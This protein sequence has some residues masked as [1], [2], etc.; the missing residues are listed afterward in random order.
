MPLQQRLL[1]L[2]GALV[3][4]LMVVNK[5]KKDKIL[6]VDSIFW[7]VSSVVMMV[8]AA[9]PE[10]AIA[11]S[12]I[13]G[14]QSPSNFVFFCVVGFL[15]VKVFGDSAEISLLKNRVD[16]LTQELALMDVGDTSHTDETN[17][18]DQDASR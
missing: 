15:F 13:L 7:V 2:C 16:E 9:V 18:S 3:A 10:L 14:F 1:L 17:G 6:M 12:R 11:F 5:I 4:M 8:V